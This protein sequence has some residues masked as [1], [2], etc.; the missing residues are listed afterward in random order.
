VMSGTWA[1]SPAAEA[2]IVGSSGTR[3]GQAG[4]GDDGARSTYIPHAQVS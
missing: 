1:A 4:E 3:A 2:K